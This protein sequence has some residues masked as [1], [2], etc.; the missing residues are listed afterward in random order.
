MAQQQSKDFLKQFQLNAGITEDEFMKI[1]RNYDADKNGFIELKELEKL[2]DDLLNSGKGDLSRDDMDL[3]KKHMLKICDGNDDKRLNLREMQSLFI[4][5]DPSPSNNA[6]LKQ[7]F[8]G[9]FRSKTGVHSVDFIKIWKKYDTDGNGYIESGELDKFLGDLM[10]EN[11]KTDGTGSLQEYKKN[12]LQF[13]DTNRDGKLDIKEMFELLPIEENFIAKFKGAPMTI[14]NFNRIFAH[15]D[16]NNDNT[17][18]GDE[19]FS[20]MKD[21]MENSGGDV[22]AKEIESYTKQMTLLLDKNK[23]NVFQKSELRELML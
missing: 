7:V 9:K 17:L 18:D 1:W 21:F 12:I 13:F 8:L 6:A 5:K 10:K 15:Y 19:L 14:N 11:Y 16:K 4:I 22:N 3:Y 23:D 20:F 2:T